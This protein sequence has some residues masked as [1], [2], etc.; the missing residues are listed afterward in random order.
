MLDILLDTVIDLLK[1]I[2]FLYIAFLIIELFEHKFSKKSKKV[3]SKS[4]KLGP[5]F[6]GL[7]GAFPQCG[8]STFA[9]NLY[10]TRIISLGT[11]ISVYLSTSDEM[12]PVLLSQNVNISIVLK[13]VGLKV[14]VGIFYGFIIDLLLRKKEKT[15]YKLCE[16]DDCDCKHSL[17]L[18][19]LKHTLK[20]LSFIF[21]ISLLLNILMAYV[22]EELLSKIFL[23]QSVLGPFIASLIGL[24]PNCGAS[25][26]ITELY[27]NSALS[28]GSMM[29]GLLTGSGVALLILFKQIKSKK[30]NVSIVLLLYLIGVI[31]G[32]IINLLGVSL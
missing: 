8:F 6:G 21:V 22:G 4:G 1:I 26:A 7:V 3:I 15:T 28:F 9:T 16:D 10:V 29:S 23:R 25:I 2:P 18:S 31:T 12:I 14:L 32:L 27:L 19:S 24:I 11:L 13:I 30:E 5:I 20:T 17:F